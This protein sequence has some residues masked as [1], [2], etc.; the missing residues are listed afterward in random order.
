[1]K[2]KKSKKIDF[3]IE[4]AERLADKYYN[5]GKY[6]NALRWAYKAYGIW[7]DGCFW[8]DVRDSYARIA[9]IY[10]AMGLHGSAVLW[11]YR[12]LHMANE[13]ELAEIYEGLAVN[14][15]N[16]GKEAQ[17]AY[18][19]NKLMD[20]DETLPPEAKVEIAEAFSR[21]CLPF[22]L[23]YNTSA[24]SPNLFFSYSYV[25]HF[26]LDSKKRTTWLVINLFLSA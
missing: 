3:S 18:Y 17:S 10:E 12:Y 9:D 6:V 25:H 23:C 14:Y 4:Q 2:D 13:D 19:Y 22:F 15:L 26:L 7:E 21:G 16:M 8:A 24:T 5:E 20:T 11:L 1:M